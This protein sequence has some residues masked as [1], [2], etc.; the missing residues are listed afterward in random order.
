MSDPDT[1]DPDPAI[2]PTAQVMAELELYGFQ[3]REDEPD[4]RPV[5]EDRVMTGAVADMFDALTASLADTGLDPDLHDLLWST[6]NTFQRAVERVE[7]LLDANEQAQ[8]QGQREQ[9]G[10][11]IRASQLEALIGAGQVLLERRDALELMR[12]TGAE[13]Y[14]NTTGNVWSPRKGSRVNHRQLTSA[15]IDSRDFIAA[16]KRAER[17]LLLPAGPR[18]AL[19]GGLDVKDHRLIWARLDQVHAKYPD[20]VLLHGKSSKGAEK[21]AACWADH[22]GVAQIGFAPDWTRHGRSAPFKRN[23]QMLD[24]LPIGVIIFPGTGIQDNLADK[25]RALG[26]PV[27]RFGGA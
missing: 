23:D 11:E 4:P 3:P 16:R 24:L 12:D 27:W 14:R 13:R 15:M 20:M 1:Y 18:I 22:R 9:D 8:K 19:T 21:I 17:E 10:S 7:R 2:S 25:A 26:I 5:P 6:V